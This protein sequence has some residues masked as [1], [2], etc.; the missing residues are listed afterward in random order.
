MLLRMTK[1]TLLKFG[2]LKKCVAEP[3]PS[4][5]AIRFPDGQ[6][7]LEPW[8][9]LRWSVAS[10]LKDSAVLACQTKSRLRPVPCIRSLLLA[11][12]REA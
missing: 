3:R 10:M 5:A 12:G 1:L 2:Y 4:S 8:M 11:L 6:A 7:A 9:S